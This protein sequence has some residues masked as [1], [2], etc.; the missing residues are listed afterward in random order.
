MSR[1]DKPLKRP[2]WVRLG[3]WGL[4]NRNNPP[5]RETLAPRVARKPGQPRGE[6]GKQGET[7]PTRRSTSP[8]GVVEANPPESCGMWVILTI[9]LK[10][11]AIF[12]I[13]WG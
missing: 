10:V 1:D 12:P 8:P 9:P 6:A 7:A 2:L 13:L 3:L 5:K 4:P 11:G